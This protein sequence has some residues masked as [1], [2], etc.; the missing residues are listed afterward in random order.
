MRHFLRVAHLV[1]LNLVQVDALCE[2][3]RL[4][5]GDD[6]HFV[7]AGHVGDHRGAH[8]RDYAAVSEYVTGSNEDFRSA[9][10]ERADSLYQRVDALDASGAQALDDAAAG[11]SWARVHDDDR[12]VVALLMRLDEKA[13]E[14]EV[15]PDDHYRV[16]ALLGEQLETEPDHFVLSENYLV[17]DEALDPVGERCLD[18]RERQAVRV[19]LTHGLHQ[20][21]NLL[22]R[23]QHAL[24][25]SLTLSDEGGSCDP[26][27]LQANQLMATELRDLRGLR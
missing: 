15:D 7:L 2:L 17:F 22:Q 24:V 1:V 9:D 18:F 6:G 19:T 12:D 25:K 21:V 23:V 27:L 5:E 13:F 26:G 10:D 3:V 20:P 14:H 11:E 8:L 16:V 4:A